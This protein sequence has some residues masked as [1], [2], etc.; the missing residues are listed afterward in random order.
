MICLLQ[1]RF[2]RNVHSEKLAVYSFYLTIYEKLKAKKNAS[3]NSDALFYY[4]K[5]A[6]QF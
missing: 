2:F 6:L 4:L 3:N 5:F 1:I